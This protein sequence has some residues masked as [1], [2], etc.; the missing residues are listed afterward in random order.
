LRPSVP[1]FDPLLAALEES[2]A[3]V[4][5]V[6]PGVSEETARRFTSQRVKVLTRPVALENILRDA[7]LAIVYG[8]GTMAD[9]LL[10]GVPLL[11]VPQV[12]EQVLVARRIEELGAGLLWGAPRTAESARAV[13]RTALNN[14]SLRAEA[15][16][17]SLRHQDF[18][19][20]KAI[21]HVVEMISGMAA[22]R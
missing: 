4:L 19:P 10:A 17:F 21:E 9:A 18:S 15:R 8:T 6:A 14:S 20:S 11:M 12:I 7:D 22:G 3:Y 2:G 16:N 5:C 1:G 13:I